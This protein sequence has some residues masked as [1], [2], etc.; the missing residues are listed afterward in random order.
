MDWKLMIKILRNPDLDPTIFIK[1]MIEEDKELLV[2]LM[3]NLV[4]KSFNNL[5]AEFDERDVC[6][7]C[8][9]DLSGKIA[10]LECGH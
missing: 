3:K 8:F 4:V 10:T 7:V 6:A 1:S 2:K 9:D 5:K